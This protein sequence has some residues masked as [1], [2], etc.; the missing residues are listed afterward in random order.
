VAALFLFAVIP[1]SRRIWNRRLLP[2]A[3]CYAVTLIFFVLANRLTTAAN[4]IFLQSAAPLYVLLLGPLLLHEPVRRRDL[5]FVAAVVCGIACFFAGSPARGAT[6]PDPARGNVFA[7][8]SGVTYALMLVGLRRLSKVTESGA[9]ATI[10]LGN[11]IACLAALP[12]A[13]PMSHITARNWA[14]LVYLGAIQIGLAYFCLAR[15]IRHV[16]AVE[17]TALLMA[18][19]ALNPVWTWLVHGETPGSLAIA[20]GALILCATLWNTLRPAR[21]EAGSSS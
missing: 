15:G 18:E 20:G 5:A 11:V 17:A 2:V 10:A 12:M 16:P 1:E 13:L 6:A 9:I 3:F 7:L 21:A 14:I 4:T 8:A 19:P